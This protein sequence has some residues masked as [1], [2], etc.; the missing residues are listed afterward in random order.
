MLREASVLKGCP[1]I[2][3]SDTPCNMKIYKDVLITGYTFLKRC[4]Y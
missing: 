2:L 4:S 1:S 3:A